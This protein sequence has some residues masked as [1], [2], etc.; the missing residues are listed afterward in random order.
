MKVREA[1]LNVIGVMNSQLGPVLQACIKAKTIESS[2]MKLLDKAISDHPYD[3]KDSC[4]EKELKCITM[5]SSNDM[6]SQPAAKSILSLPK[7]DIMASLRSDYLDRLNSTEGK[8]AWKI[9]RDAMEE[10]RVGV[11]KC[12]ALIATEGN[13]FLSLKQLF[14]ALRSRL[15][16]SQSNLKPAAASLIGML[17]NHVDDDSQAK[18]G[19]IVFAALIHAAANDMKKTM[20]EAAIAALAMGTESSVHNGGGTNLIATECFIICLES[21]MSEATLKSSGLPDVISFLT[22]KLESLYPNEETGKRRAISVNRQLAKVIVLCLLSSKA[23]T[24]SAAESLLGKCT[25]SRIVLSED[26]DKEIGQLLPAQQRTVRSVIPTLAKQEQPVRPSSSSRLPA[27]QAR[28]NSNQL[29]IAPPAHEVLASETCG[30]ANPLRRGTTNSTKKQRLLQAKSDNWPEYPEQPNGDTL[31]SICKAWS[32]LIS[33]VSIQLLFPKDGLRSHEDA[34]SG[35]DLISTAI[36]YSRSN[37]DDEFLE[38]LDLI[39]K[40]TACALY[41]RDHTSG[42]RSLISMLQLLFKRL[43]E[44]SYVMTDYEAIILLPTILEKTGNAKSQCR[45]QLIDTLSFIRLNEL[46]QLPRY[47]SI[48]CMKVLEKSNSTRARSLAA[49]ECISCVKVAGTVAIG[50]RGVETLARA[51]STEKFLEVR[52]SYLDLFENVVQKSSLEKVLKLCVGDTVTEKTRGMIIDRCSRRPSTTPA[53][54]DT[55]FA[56][57]SDQRQSRLTPTRKSVTAGSNQV[58][59]S[60]SAVTGALKLRLQRLKVENQTAGGSSHI[61]STTS[62]N[63][64]IDFYASTLND[65]T[66]M[67][68]GE[69]TI[70]QGLQAIRRLGSEAKTEIQKFSSDVNRFVEIFAGA[71]KFAFKRSTLHISLIQET[72]DSLTHVFRTPQYYSAVSQDSLECCTREAVH[73][74]LD[75]RLDASKGANTDGIDIIIKGINKVRRYVQLCFIMF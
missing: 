21:T 41:S 42:L 8:T 38:E 71:L 73:A 53:P 45:D 58:A 50:K 74:L 46:Y 12:G 68:N 28:P 69:V 49:N 44:L 62:V 2:T 23:G 54:D 10:I 14:A 19:K 18:L 13:S 34:I 55:K 7:T 72:V 64:D 17:L 16:D 9:R 60:S 4:V 30:E 22:A 29:V 65:I 1:A 11:E 26:F 52:T 70:E 51:L 20:R 37:N 75:D 3:A 59:S 40:W 24:R 48:I 47:G 31:L 43:R 32:Q 5:L 57:R 63:E 27:M 39:F 61:P 33:P 25:T 35:C 67:M 56:H 15:N 66:G 6:S 36:E